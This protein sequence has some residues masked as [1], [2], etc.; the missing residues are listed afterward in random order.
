MNCL[1]PNMLKRIAR[2]VELPDLYRM[3]DRRDKLQ[4]KLFQKK[5]ELLFEDES[6]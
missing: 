4:S 3:E 5:I 1:N 2:E 6:N